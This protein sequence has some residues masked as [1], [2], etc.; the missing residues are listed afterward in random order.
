MMIFFYYSFF[1]KYHIA[2]MSNQHVLSFLFPDGPYFS[3]ATAGIQGEFV[4]HVYMS[5][6]VSLKASESSFIS[7]ME[8]GSWTGASTLTW[9]QAIDSYC[10][11]AGEVLCVDPW[12]PYFSEEQN[13]QGENYRIMSNMAGLDIVYDLFLHNIK[14][15]QQSTPVKHMR[16]KSIDIPPLLKEESFDVIY[17]DGD[18]AYE[19]AL[20]DIRLA[21]QLVKIGGFICGDDLEVQGAE[22]D[23]EFIKK[24]LKYDFLRFPEK[25]LAFHPGVTLAVYEEFSEVSAYHGFGIMRKVAEDKFGKVSLSGQPGFIP[26][27]FPE[28]E[29][30]MVRETLGQSF[31]T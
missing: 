9:C 30:E 2:N 3:G 19:S 1:K 16:G 13:E 25:N 26:S 29:K 28:R 14:F 8:I 24:N 18:H 20:Y 23:L 31:Q 7:L 4:R 22:S 6:A 5:A 11:D 17:I 27:H 10:P 21:K 12:S 15:A